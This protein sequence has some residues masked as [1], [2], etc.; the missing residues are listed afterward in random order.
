MTA[1][2]ILK[3]ELQD[4]WTAKKITA[5][6]AETKSVTTKACKLG[7]LLPLLGITVIPKDNTTALWDGV[8]NTGLDVSR[9][10]IA[11]NTSLKLTFDGAGD[12]WVLY[13]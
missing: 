7:R 3:R 11:V 2:E 1:A 6:G 10:P 4:G 12:C 13:K 5:T 8:T 9:T